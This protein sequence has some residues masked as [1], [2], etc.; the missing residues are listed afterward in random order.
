MIELCLAN[1]FGKI[2]M[3]GGTGKSKLRLTGYSGFGLIPKERNTVQYAGRDGQ[4][5]VSQTVPARVMTLTGDIEVDSVRDA[6]KQL[7]NMI[8]VFDHPCTLTIQIHSKIRAV[9]CVCTNL[10][11]DDKTRAYQKF[12]AQFIA[13]IPYFYD[14]KPYRISVFGREKLIKSNIKTPCLFS[15]RTNQ[16]DIRICGGV[17]V[18][19]VFY[20]YSGDNYQGEIEIRNNTY[21]QVIRFTHEVKK[22]ETIQIDVPNRKILSDM[23]GNIT[24]QISDD[25]FL[26]NF[27][28]GV[29]TNEIQLLSEHK[30]LTAVCEYKNLY[31]EAVI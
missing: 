16:A 24:Y 21:N 17:K 27:W 3:S 25:T 6:T 28:L 13:D 9:D 10:E 31:I 23:D 4:W 7:E 1:E 30:N 8:H 20:I 22:G 19:P 14:P 2:Y 5:L 26:S 11:F 29:G 18:E 12:T 15:R